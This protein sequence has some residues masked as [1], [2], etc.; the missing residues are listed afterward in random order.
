MAEWTARLAE[1]GPLHDGMKEAC[2]EAEA[3]ATLSS[4]DCYRLPFLRQDHRFLG[5]L[6]KLVRLFGMEADPA[7][8]AYQQYYVTLATVNEVVEA[9]ALGLKEMPQLFERAVEYSELRELYGQRDTLH[10]TWEQMQAR[11][12]EARR[13]VEAFGNVIAHLEVDPAD[14]DIAQRWQE[15]YQADAQGFAAL[16]ESFEEEHLHLYQEYVAPSHQDLFVRVHDIAAGIAKPAADRAAVEKALERA[17]ALAIALRIDAKLPRELF[18]ALQATGDESVFVE[19]LKGLVGEKHWIGDKL[20]SLRGRIEKVQAVTAEDMARLEGLRESIAAVVVG[21]PPVLDRKAL[22]QTAFIEAHPERIDAMLA[23]LKAFEHDYIADEANDEDAEADPI[24][25]IYEEQLYRHF[26]GLKN[27]ELLAMQGRALEEAYGEV[28]RMAPGS[29]EAFL[30]ARKAFDSQWVPHAYAHQALQADIKALEEAIAHVDEPRQ[31]YW[32]P[33]VQHADT[34]LQPEAFAALFI[35]AN[36]CTLPAIKG[37]FKEVLVP[38]RKAF[39]EFLAEIQ[40]DMRVAEN[41]LVQTLEARAALLGA[42]TPSEAIAAAKAFLA[43][44]ADFTRLLDTTIDGFNEADE[45]EEFHAYREANEQDEEGV[46]AV[47]F[48]LDKEAVAELSRRIDAVT[49]VTG[50][51]C[52]ISEKQLAAIPGVKGNDRA[53]KA[54]RSIL[55]PPEL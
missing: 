55:A 2:A 53:L 48:R 34:L 35:S 40:Q 17:E 39:L 19:K 9:V 32:R 8:Q 14:A 51:T 42:A 52:L 23:K 16:V 30:A 46:G 28:L 22:S 12:Q 18:A 45:A 25:R 24:H 47:I 11:L 29:V 41:A 6:D 10:A 31:R 7:L 44:F 5:D 13:A 37:H 20:L 3:M 4:L 50:E 33:V 26:A 54:I 36:K 27:W 49:E 15:Q 38:G 43:T 1:L 21:L